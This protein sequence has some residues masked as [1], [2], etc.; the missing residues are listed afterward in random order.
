LRAKDEELA[1]LKKEALAL[2]VYKIK[3]EVLNA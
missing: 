1:T 3:K 2:Q